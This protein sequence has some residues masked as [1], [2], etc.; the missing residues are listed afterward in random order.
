M[1]SKDVP[2]EMKEADRLVREAVSRISEHADAVTV[3]VT[4]RMENGKDGTWRMAFGAGNWYT[5]YGQ[6]KH[7]CIQEEKITEDED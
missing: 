2:E 1:D 7:W 3:F 4:K 5:R 6:I